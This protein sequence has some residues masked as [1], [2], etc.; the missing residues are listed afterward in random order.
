MQDN[1]TRNRNRAMDMSGERLVR[2]IRTMKHD[3]LM[4]GDDPDL[5]LL[6]PDVARRLY[7]HLR[8]DL[9][10]AN[11]WHYSPTRNMFYEGMRVVETRSKGQVEV[12]SIRSLRM[13]P[14][15]PGLEGI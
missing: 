7:H 15:I 11:T 1:S 13:R 9:V 12:V 5:L 10:H 6:G 3:V 8:P 14:R 2:E 4:D